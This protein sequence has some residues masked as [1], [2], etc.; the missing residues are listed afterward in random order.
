MDDTITQLLSKERIPK[1]ALVAQHFSREHLK[2]PTQCIREQLG[3]TGIGGT[4]R[5]GM[6]VAITAGSREIDNSVLI[7]REI[8]SF[9]KARGGKPFLIPAM[10]SHGGATAAGQEAFLGVYGITEETVGAP[11]CS[12]MEVV[13]IATL[14]DGRLVLIDKYAAGADGIILFN[15]VKPHTAFHDRFESGLFKMMAIGLGKQYGASVVH[16]E[17]SA[18]MGKNIQ[19]FG[20]SILQHANILFGVATIENPFH[21]T[22]DIVALTREEIPK[23][24]PKLLERAKKNIAQ[25]LFPKLDVLVVGEM[26]KNISGTGMDPNVTHAYAPEA[27]L[28]LDEK[29]QRIAVLSLTE[30]THGCANG[31]GLADVT[32]DRVVN[33][34]DQGSSY[35]NALT[36]RSSMVVK[37]PMHMP[38]DRLAIQAA[39]A[40][41][42]GRD[43][44]RLRMVYIENTLHLERI[45]IAESMVEEAMALEDTEVLEAPRPL[46][47]NLD[48]CLEERL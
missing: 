22:L 8:V 14:G 44:E 30:E 26:G 45:L 31:I 1:M 43:K 5:P 42:Y 48:N 28:A 12:S 4:I 9:V 2:D 3:K 35:A 24:E 39:I 37:I 36:A 11:I 25:I 21:K 19:L 20:E 47:F 6:T 10:G 32:T 17:G 29:P 7:L 33:A 34:F 40:L 27:G 41:T 13:Q 38:N 23:E 18:S 16:R 15:R 46:H